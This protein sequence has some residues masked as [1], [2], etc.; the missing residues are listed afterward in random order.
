MDW[1]R[2]VRQKAHL[3]KQILIAQTEKELLRKKI[4][5]TKRSKSAQERLVRQTLGYVRVGESVIELD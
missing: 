3:E 5:E 4:V 1:R 2:I